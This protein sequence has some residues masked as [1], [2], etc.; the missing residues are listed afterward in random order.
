MW[1]L[2]APKRALVNRTLRG[3]GSP[4]RSDLDEAFERLHETGK[5]V[6]VMFSSDE[7]LQF[8]LA[9]SGELAELEQRENV[10]L[11][12]V[13]VRDHTCRPIWAQRQVH[14]ILDRALER[15]VE[16]TP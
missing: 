15:E 4:A 16:R 12:T 13:A 1:M 9:R 14:A 7:P 3:G 5:R 2:A 8:E 10:T 6:M 11:E